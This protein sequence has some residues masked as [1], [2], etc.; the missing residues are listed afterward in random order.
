MSLA[1]LSRPPCEP[2]IQEAPQASRFA[3][4]PASW[5]LLCSSCALTRRPVS[6]QMLG[7]SLA[8]F[9]TASDKPVV[10]D[11]HWQPTGSTRST[12]PR[13]MPGD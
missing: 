3:A 9:R 2:T 7:R 10:M 12:L 1:E 4:Y 6:R 11:G 13:F 8:A 5:Y